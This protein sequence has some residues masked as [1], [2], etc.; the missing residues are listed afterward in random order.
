[1]AKMVENLQ[2]DKRM[3]CFTAINPNTPV[4]FG[5][6]AMIGMQV[7]RVR[8]PAWPYSG[9]PAAATAGNGKEKTR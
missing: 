1:M 9:N 8:F 3:E 6:K 2:T 5:A 4:T 7:C